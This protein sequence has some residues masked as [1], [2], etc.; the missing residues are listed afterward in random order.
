[1]NVITIA[2]TIEIS[3]IVCVGTTRVFVCVCVKCD[4]KNKA[5]KAY[6]HKAPVKMIMW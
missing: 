1:M 2:Q 5:P 6:S 4:I 3:V